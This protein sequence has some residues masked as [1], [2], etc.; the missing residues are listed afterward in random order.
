MFLIVHVV[1]TG[2]SQRPGGSRESEMWSCQ[3]VLGPWTGREMRLSPLE[4]K[5]RAGRLINQW[6]G[7]GS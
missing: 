2:G 5:G 1:Q 7:R 3:M 4:V 6:L